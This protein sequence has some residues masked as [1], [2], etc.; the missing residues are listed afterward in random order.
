MPEIPITSFKGIWD[1]LS[2]F[3]QLSVSKS[4][5][6]DKKTSRVLWK[7]PVIADFEQYKIKHD[8]LEKMSPNLV[9]RNTYNGKIWE[10]KWEHLGVQLI[11]QLRSVIRVMAAAHMGIAGRYTVYNIPDE[12]IF[13]VADIRLFYTDDKIKAIYAKGIHK[14]TGR[15]CDCHPA[16]KFSVDQSPGKKLFHQI[17]VQMD[18]MFDDFF[19]GMCECYKYDKYPTKIY[20]DSLT[21]KKCVKKRAQSNWY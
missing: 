20:K 6:F 17:N 3:D 2:Y 15:G 16:A 13:Y 4:G 14:R 5:L 9:T 12:I 21:C 19:I 18:D 1:R 8:T 10:W 11:V 7:T